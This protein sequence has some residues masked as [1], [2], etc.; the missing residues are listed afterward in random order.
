[1]AQQALVMCKTCLFQESAFTAA[2]VPAKIVTAK[3]FG[4]SYSAN[5]LRFTVQTSATSTTCLQTRIDIMWGFT[6]VRDFACR[7][8]E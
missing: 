3:E 2:F 4:H 7:I 6:H 1:M 8:T 5:G